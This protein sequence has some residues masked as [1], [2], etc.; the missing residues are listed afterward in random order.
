MLL[1]EKHK[2]LEWGIYS[3]ALGLNAILTNGASPLFIPGVLITNIPLLIKARQV[4]NG[5]IDIHLRLHE[6]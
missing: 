2:P 4:C 1:S 3:P 6:S 5:P